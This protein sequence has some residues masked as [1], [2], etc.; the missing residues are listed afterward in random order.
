MCSLSW[1][2]TD[3]GYDLYFNRDE[4]H[5]RPAAHPPEPF[6][7]D[8]IWVLMPR[9]PQAGGSWISVNEKGLS[10]ALLNNYQDINPFDKAGTISR[11]QLVR[12]LSALTTVDEVAEALSLFT[13]TPFQPFTLF[14][15]DP[16][17]QQQ[18]QWSGVMLTAQKAVR[19]FASSGYDGM[20]VINARTAAYDETTFENR[21]DHRAFHRRCQATDPA[22]AICMQRADA[23]TRNY[24]EIF[25]TS[26]QIH[27]GFT[28]GPPCKADLQ[29]FTLPVA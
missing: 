28:D 9:D 17:K 3:A 20:A 8:G 4:Q 19:F 24:T 6:M 14:V 27:M 18:F 10:L 22:Y 1:C 11:G 5:T 7:L 12:Q 2:R 15:F 29:I 23:A 25:V 26:Q 21:D 16:V 13:L